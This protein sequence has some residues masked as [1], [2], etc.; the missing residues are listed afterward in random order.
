MLRGVVTGG[1]Q[2]IGRAI[3]DT[4]HQAGHQVVVFDIKPSDDA[5]VRALPQQGVF[6]CTVDVAKV[7]AIKRGFAFVD[8]V[9]NHAA[10]QSNLDF[11]INNAGITSDGL[12]V[13]MSEASW[14]RVLNVN[15]KGAFFCS[16]QAL[17][18]FL[19]RDKGYIINMS[20]V[21]GTTG[22]IGQANYAASKAG[23]LA[24]TK[25][26]AQEYASK[27]ILVNAIAPG[28]I[29]TS[30]THQLPERVKDFAR[31][32]IPLTRFGSVDDVANMVAF[33]L[34][35]KADYLT[36]QVFGVNGGMI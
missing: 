10:T 1:L 22:N 24:L 5:L 31:N 19:K 21:V 23:L 26:L 17:K 9:F 2:G 32:R 11:L 3:V 35:G 12:A 7:D 30:M 20:S 27:N 34:S 33:L 29:E 36:G 8:T 15:L 18:R 14:D 16:Q 25:S 13:R 28:F 6:Y 4:L